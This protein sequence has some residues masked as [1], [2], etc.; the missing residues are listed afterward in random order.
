M[1]KLSVSISSRKPRRHRRRRRI[2][3]GVFAVSGLLLSIG[4]A[5]EMYTSRLQAA[6]LSR[7]AQE[8]SFRLE[9]GPSPAI[10]FPQDGPYDRRL[11]YVDTPLFAERLQKKG[12]EIVAQTR[13]S[14]RA[15]QLSGRGIAIP[16]REKIQ[17][18][19][20]LLDRL[21][22]P[23]FQGNYPERVYPSFEAIP[24]L[25]VA[26][27]LFIENRELLYPASPTHNP[28]VEW[29]R[30]ARAGLD[31]LA[32]KI[33]DRWQLT[34]GST[35]ATQLEK[36]R[37]SPDGRTES[38]K[39]KLKQIVSASLR[40]YRQGEET[41][42]VR[43]QIVLNYI[44]SIPL[45]AIPGYGEVNGL[46]DG[47]WY[48]FGADFDTVNR[49]LAQS[50]FTDRPMPDPAAW[51][52]AYRQVL[53]LFLAHRAPSVY[54]GTDQTALERQ[55]ERYLRLLADEGIL[56]PGMRDLAL[57]TSPPL[58]KQAPKPPD[59]SFV[60]RKAINAVRAHLLN[61]LEISRLYELDRLDLTVTS[62]LDREMQECVTRTLRQLQDPVYA[63]NAGLYGYRLLGQAEDPGKVVY[64]MTLYERGPDR[65]WLRIQADTWDSPLDINQGAKLELGSTAKLRTLVTYLE[66]IAALHQRYAG[67]SPAELAAVPLPSAR[68]RLSR[69]ALEYL[70]TAADTS[71]TG[72]LQAAL[73][74]G[75]SS[76]PAE[77]FFT[78]GGM[79]TFSNFDSKDFG[80]FMTVRAA[81]YNSVNLVFIRMM[82]DIVHY[83]MYQIPG[84]SA[85]VLEDL[86]DS[87]RQAYLK[88]FAD[89]EGRIF[90]R[91]FYQKYQGKSLEESLDILLSGRQHMTPSRLA[92]V[93]F[94]IKTEVG[95]E[96][97]GEFLY[98]NLP[99]TMI[100]DRAIQA[101]HQRYVR[102]DYSLGDLGYIARI[103]PLELWLVGY[104][105][106]HRE[107]TLSEVLEASYAERLA[108]Y[109]W[110]FKTRR[111]HAQDSRILTMLENEAFMEIH[112]AWK[113]LGY[114][115][116]SLVPSYATAIGSSGD[117]PA[118]LAELMGIIL[119]DGIRN[120]TVQV[121]RLHFG[122]DTPYE[123]VASRTIAPGERVMAPEVARVLREMLTGVVEQGTAQRIRNT[124][125]DANGQP[126]PVG[127][128][129]G[130][131][132]NRFEVYNRA[133][134]M[135]ASHVINRTAT[136]AF[137]IGDRFYGTV[138]AY[139]PG[140][141]A[142]R[143][144][145]TSGLPVQVLKHLAPDLM[146][147][148]ESA[149]T[150]FER[151]S[152][153]NPDIPGAGG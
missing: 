36:F 148:L 67:R 123:T 116:E 100:S 29:D 87:T 129:T 52:R 32:H 54:L 113:R 51:A 70:S 152:T 39:D 114:P 102:A 26:T 91:R 98:E 65:N 89:R 57:Q 53:S 76:N 137:F 108:V 61:L 117:R 118:A 58:R 96:A 49:L 86:Q 48:W 45:A 7:L 6:V 1:S 3:L 83:Y 30:L 130:T 110:L 147:L 31:Y 22:R 9:D 73:D 146:P 21:Y 44:N 41:G 153:G 125:V 5:V 33:D 50:S 135:I 119:N 94:A 140:K 11:G 35:L 25:V 69:W 10:R 105:R 106:R 136:F 85:R 23:V 60:E 82:R 138:T 43:K 79:H 88:K 16:Y 34:G 20:T 115:F 92:A 145:F 84:S 90:L 126:V 37:H 68:D 63:A 78:G 103:H 109:E 18:G 8:V 2:I 12:F 14:E 38:P 127:G 93:F 121:E 120:P 133:G 75:Y 139:V 132:D 72:M 77:R 47:L 28:V 95:V 27:L 111:K 46:G 13:L 64:S 99:N 97:L 122:K 17:A 131:G 107:A 74:R 42:E 144:H 19:L 143:Y 134:E 101:L 24:P 112:R 66:V 128:K 59:Y 55:T 151:L 149:A 56:T 141:D 80:G 15:L 150:P 81:F 4:V 142:A 62:T 40:V 104:L 124:F 71:L